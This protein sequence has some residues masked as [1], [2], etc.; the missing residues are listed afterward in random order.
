VRFGFT[1]APTA[2]LFPEISQNFPGVRAGTKILADVEGG[3]AP[4]L[5]K[6]TGGAAY[7]IYG[8]EVK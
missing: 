6:S 2:G 8:Y 7:T 3:E 5:G 4:A 1:T